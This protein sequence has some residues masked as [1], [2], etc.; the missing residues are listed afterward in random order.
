[1][2]GKVQ[3]WSVKELQ[4]NLAT[5][6]EQLDQVR[7]LLDAEPGNAEY[8]EMAVGLKEVLE[9]TEDLLKTAKQAE[10]ANALPLETDLDAL[11]L[12]GPPPHPQDLSLSD[13]I[14][15]RLPAGSKLLAVWSE[16]GE[17]YT[18][19]VKAVTPIGYIV[20]YDDWG[21]TEEVDL[22]NVRALETGEDD[23]GSEA[24]SDLD[25][26]IDEDADALLGAE[27]D[28][29]AT[30]QAIK[31]KIAQAAD[32]DVISRDLPPKLRINSD[33]PEDVKAAKKKKIH[34][35]KSKARLE[36]MELTQNKR[37]NAWHQFQTS[38]GKSKKVGFFTGRKRESIFK[39][40]D[41]PKGK[42]GVTGSGKGTTG[43]QKREKHLHLRVAGEDGDDL[44]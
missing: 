4:T 6:H 44:I 41:D 22:S 17:W 11:S 34:S 5:Y 13:D 27:R 31:R 30:R 9:L 42:V 29:E 33:D 38:K 16:D 28:A 19:T 35:F 12:P 15:G 40:P 43:F 3:E 37:Q 39:S 8:V 10:A 26:N 25:I 24:K 1:M 7:Q 2:V 18:A 21:N 36:Q 20:T 14:A 23:V 32:V